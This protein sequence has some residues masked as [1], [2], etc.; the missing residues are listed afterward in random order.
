M[1][2]M[3]SLLFAKLALA[4]VLGSGAI[5]ALVGIGVEPVFALSVVIPTVFYQVYTLLRNPIERPGPFF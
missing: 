2:E 3:Y 4:G 1:R 5:L